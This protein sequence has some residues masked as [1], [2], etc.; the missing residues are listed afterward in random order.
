[1]RNNEVGSSKKKA[2]NGKFS[3]GATLK[4]LK[5]LDSMV[6]VEYLSVEGLQVPDFPF[7]GMYLKCVS[8]KFDKMR[9]RFDFAVK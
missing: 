1:M 9:S 8:S 2:L 5:Y 4:I 3:A 7:N 6:L